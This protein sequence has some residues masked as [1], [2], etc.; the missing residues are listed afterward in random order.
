MRQA[1]RCRIGVVGA[2][3]AGLYLALLL[4][5]AGHRVT[6]FEKAP[7][8]RVDGCGILLVAS[9]LAAVA[10]GVA[11]DVLERVLAGGLP[12]QRFVIRNL[13]G[14]QIESSP[15]PPPEN[16][17]LPSLL[18]HR[19][20][21]LAA[22]WQGFDAADFR[23]AHALESWRQ[24][25]DG[26]EACFANGETWRGDLL[27]G[28]DGL[29]SRVAPS[30]VPQRRLNYLGDRVWRGVV[31]DGEF[32]TEGSFFVYARGRGIYANFFDLGLSPEGTPLTHWGFFHEEPLPVERSE[33]RRLLA[34]PIPPEA[35][36]RLPE[37]AARIIA[38][39][40]AEEMVAN[41]SFD[42]DPLP[43][44]H[45]GRVAL[46]GDAAH[47]MSSSRARGM[48]AGLEDALVL[49]GALEETADP[50]QALVRYGEQRLPVVHR[51]Q[52]SSREVSNRIGRSRR[53]QPRPQPAAV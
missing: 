26:V 52:A 34:E 5:R 17:Q 16:G 2:G 40:P 36:E 33:Q 39:T 25:A 22:L 24:N 45:R 3:T 12:V 30:L 43:I 7:D 6:L 11:D 48:T 29:F 14:G 20:A 44:L 23:G 18:I 41:W 38:A 32:C 15:A 19:K 42:I 1:T 50:R 28:A 13:R 9:G 21:I 10:A 53:P 35:L 4:Q 37:D 49:A 47:A 8:P 51:Y 27:I 46:I 31:E